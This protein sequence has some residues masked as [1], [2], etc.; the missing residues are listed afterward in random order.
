MIGDNQHAG[1][2]S[3]STSNQ[4]I[5]LSDRS[6]SLDA[7]GIVTTTTVA[8]LESTI[9]EE[10]V[11]VVDDDDDDE[12]DNL[13]TTTKSSSMP[14]Q[15]INSHHNHHNFDECTSWRNVIVDN[16]FEEKSST[17][18][19]SS[20]SK[21][22]RR[23]S[24]SDPRGLALALKQMQANIGRLSRNFLFWFDEIILFRFA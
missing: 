8:D 10:D 24:N 21:H 3:A 4:Q 20:P 7:S 14:P 13:P 15:Q 22:F 17:S 16:R 19:N 9:D 23:R 5:Y 6:Q 2:S 11:D 12:D 18:K 1:P